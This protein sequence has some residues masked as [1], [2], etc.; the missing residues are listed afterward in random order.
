MSDTFGHLKWDPR[1][2]SGVLGDG[3]FDYDAQPA[4]EVN[5]VVVEEEEHGGDQIPG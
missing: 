3:Q 1:R 2:L 4:S 5:V